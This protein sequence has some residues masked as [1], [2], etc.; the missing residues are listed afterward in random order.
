M[1]TKKIIAES[2]RDRFY[3]TGLTITHKD[4]L[5]SSKWVGKSN[6]GEILM[7]VRREINQNVDLH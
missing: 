1:I 4:V 5:Q 3:A 7:N 6:L 2:G